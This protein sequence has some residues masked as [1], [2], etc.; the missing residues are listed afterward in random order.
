MS[1]VLAIIRAST[2][3]QETESQKLELLEY[4]KGFGY[5][6]ESVVI[7]EVAGASAYKKNQKYLMMLEKIKNDILADP[8]IKAVGLWN[9][10]RLGRVDDCLIEMKNW[11]IKHKIQLYCKSP[12][13][14]L[15]NE[16]GTVNGGAEIA[17]GVFA[18]LVKQQTEDLFNKWKRGKDRNK[19]NG[20]FNGGRY[21][22]GIGYTVNQDGYIIEDPEETKILLKLF[23]LYSEGNSLDYVYKSAIKLGRKLTKCNLKVILRNEKYRGTLIPEDIFDKVQEIR[24]SRAYSDKTRVHRL[25]SGLVICPECRSTFVRH[26]KHLSCNHHTSEYKDHVKYCSC[27]I[28]LREEMIDRIIRETSAFLEARDIVEGTTERKENIRSEI[29]EIPTRIEIQRSVIEGISKKLEKLTD[30]YVDGLISKEKMQEKANKI[31][32]TEKEA[33]KEIDNLR[34]KE[35]LLQ[36]ELERIEGNSLYSINS[37]GELQKKLMYSPDMYEISRRHIERIEVD[38]DHTGKDKIIT[39]ITKYDG[40]IHRFKITSCSGKKSKLIYLDTGGCEIMV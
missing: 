33:L 24:K 29:E 34:M 13:L 17:Y 22:A 4:L 5:S 19:R 12:S 3:R 21:G 10:D 27:T 38:R 26:D 6:K 35:R 31:K 20:K 32:S 39:L 18:S 2:D 36:E 37:I 40:Y 8:D 14:V 11:F 15:L 16:D 7:I 23:K 30:S 28:T 25:Y 9:L 1:K